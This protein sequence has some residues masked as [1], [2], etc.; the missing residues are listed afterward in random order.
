MPKV[1]YKVATKDEVETA[2]LSRKSISRHSVP[3]KCNAGD[4]LISFLGKSYKEIYRQAGGMGRVVANFI[5]KHYNFED[6][7]YYL[8]M[9]VSPYLIMNASPEGCYR[10][11]CEDLGLFEV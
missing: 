2:D 7:N 6:P 11:G 9:N 8:I 5:F 4:L 1:M 10:A 3:G